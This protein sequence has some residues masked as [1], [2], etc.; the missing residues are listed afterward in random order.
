MR[1]VSL[2]I[3]LLPKGVLVVMLVL[4]SCIEYVRGVCLFVKRHISAS[5]CKMTDQIK[6]L[7]GV[8]TPGG[9]WNIVLDVD[10]DPPSERG[11]GPTFKFPDFRHISGMT[12]ARDLTFCVHIRGWGP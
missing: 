12:E 8:N 9:P 5:L 10:P 2:V 4:L 7:F 6:M 3:S 11:R 1:V